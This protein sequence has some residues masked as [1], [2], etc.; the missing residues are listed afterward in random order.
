MCSGPRTWYC[1]RGPRTPETARR[2]EQTF[3][4]HY[5]AFHPLVLEQARRFQQGR[6]TGQ[7]SSTCTIDPRGGASASFGDAL[8]LVRRARRRRAKAAGEGDGEVLGSD[9]LCLHAADGRLHRVQI[10]QAG[11]RQVEVGPHWDGLQLRVGSGPDEAL[12]V[13]H[14]LKERVQEG[15]TQLLVAEDFVDRDALIGVALEANGVEVGL[16]G[17]GEDLGGEVAQRPEVRLGQNPRHEGHVHRLI[18]GQ[19]ELL[20]RGQLDV[21]AG[22]GVATTTASNAGPAD[23]FPAKTTL[24]PAASVSTA[25][26]RA[27]SWRSTCAAFSNARG[28]CSVPLGR[29]NTDPTRP[30]PARDT[31]STTALMSPS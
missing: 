6:Q 23:W 16:P 20:R 2:D 29:E 31:A 7:P 15:A 13:H 18:L 1:Y 17:L 12:D 28:S 30:A 3:D 14:S 5:E 10:V 27:L 25:V 4:E 26:T 11:V 19:V 24:K 8:L 22:Q 21:R 9:E